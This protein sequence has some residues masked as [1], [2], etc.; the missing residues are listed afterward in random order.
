MVEDAGDLKRMKGRPR[1]PFWG[2]DP[3]AFLEAMKGGG[4]GELF[5]QRANVS[6]DPQSRGL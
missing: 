4:E 2:E 5:R 6:P 3:P 1:W